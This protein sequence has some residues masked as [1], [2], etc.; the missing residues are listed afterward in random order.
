MRE[1]HPRAGPRSEAGAPPRCAARGAVGLKDAPQRKGGARGSGYRGRWAQ[2]AHVLSRADRA[3]WAAGV[4]E[5]LAGVLGRITL[6]RRALDGHG[7]L[8]PGPTAGTRRADCAQ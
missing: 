8:P 6:P 2:Q 7:D 5:R 1:A 3:R 4:E